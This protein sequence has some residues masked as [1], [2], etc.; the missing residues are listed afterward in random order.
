MIHTDWPV[1]VWESSRMGLIEE[2]GGVNNYINTLRQYTV[3]LRS[4]HVFTDSQDIR[5][6]MGDGSRET[7]NPE[8]RNFP[9]H[10]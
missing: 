8:V 3:V 7:L 10:D 6:K 4:T 2:R 9:S 1:A 5:S